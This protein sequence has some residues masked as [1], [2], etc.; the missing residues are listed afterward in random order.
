[1]WRHQLVSLAQGSSLVESQEIAALLTPMF[2][3]DFP[4]ETL[5]KLAACCLEELIAEDLPFDLISR[6]WTHF[7]MAS[8]WMVEK[9]A[10]DGQVTHVMASKPCELVHKELSQGRRRCSHSFHRGLWPV[11]GL[12]P[13]N[14]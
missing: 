12:L 8:G 11:L 9:S 5:I 7:P 3:I 1:M 14:L 6:S 13:A 4:R 10:A 2:R